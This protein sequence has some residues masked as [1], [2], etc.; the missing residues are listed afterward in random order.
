MA[1]Q[2]LFEGHKEFKA[3]T[4]CSRQ[5]KGRK[6][7]TYDLLAAPQRVGNKAG[8]GCVA[9]TVRSCCPDSVPKTAA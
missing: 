1:H 6:G 7:A 8:A 5:K 3:G 9:G 2:V 4:S